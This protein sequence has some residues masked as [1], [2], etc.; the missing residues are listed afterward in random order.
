MAELTPQEL[1]AIKSHHP[2][3]RLPDSCYADGEPWPCLRYRLV[4]RIEELEKAVE[5]AKDVAAFEA[6][7]NADVPT[8]AIPE[9]GLYPAATSIPRR[10]YFGGTRDTA[11]AAWQ[12]ALAALEAGDG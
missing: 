11:W 2:S 4:S 9:I 5:T 1:E 7:W 3:G 10:I 8:P 6:W 12:A